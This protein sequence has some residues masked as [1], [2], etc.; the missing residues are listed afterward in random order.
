MK[1]ELEKCLAGEPFYGGDPEIVK[2]AAKAKRLTRELNDTGYTDIEKKR[3]IMKQLFEKKRGIMKQLFGSVG[4]RVH[5]DVDFHC[6]YGRHIFI[7]DRV[8]INMNC[9]FV[10]NNIIEIGN[11]VLI[12]SNVQIYTATHSTRYVERI[13]PDDGGDDCEFCLTYAKPVKICDGAWLGGG[14][15]VL[16]GVTIGRNSVVGAGSVVTRSIPDNCVAVGNPCRVIKNIDNR[17]KP[18]PQQQ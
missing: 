16:P 6:E 14:V 8:I 13:L 5:I 17:E 10:D 9:T 3:G 12:A 18:I 2:I 4:R 15:I 11:D 1:T 7:G